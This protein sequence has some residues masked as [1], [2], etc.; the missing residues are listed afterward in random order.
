MTAA[1]TRLASETFAF[2]CNGLRYLATVSRFAD[3]RLA[4]L[5]LLAMRKRARILTR[6]PRTRRWSARLRCNTACRST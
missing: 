1:R 3:G 6:P 4:E 2:E 5:F